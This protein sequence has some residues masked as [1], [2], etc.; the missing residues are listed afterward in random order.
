[1]PGPPPLPSP[2][3]PTPAD[4]RRHRQTGD[5]DP[6]QYDRCWAELPAEG[7]DR[8]DL[9]FF[10]CTLRSAGTHVRQM[11]GGGD[12]PIEHLAVFPTAVVVLAAPPNREV[13]VRRHPLGTLTWT[14]AKAA[15][16]RGITDYVANLS[17]SRRGE[18]A[19]A[20]AL[21]V[22]SEAGEQTLVLRS[23]S[24]VDDLRELLPS[25]VLDRARS[26]VA[27]GRNVR[28]ED[29]LARIPAGTKAHAAAERLRAE[30]GTIATVPADHRAGL[31]GVA[32]GARGRLRFDRRGLEFFDEIEGRSV[33]VPLTHVKRVLEVRKG[34]YPAEY[35]KRIEAQRKKVL[36]ARWAI[37]DPLIYLGAQAAV[38]S[39]KQELAD[40]RYG[41]PLANR[42]VLLVAIQ[43]KA[44]PV[45]FDVAGTERSAVERT[46]SEF[47][48]HLE[49]LI[50]GREPTTP[51]G[52][53]YGWEPPGIR[54]R[55]TALR[56]ANHLTGEDYGFLMTVLSA[57]SRTP[58]TAKPQAASK[59][60]EI[61]IEVKLP[62]PAKAKSSGPPPVPAA[63]PPAAEPPPV[64]KSEPTEPISAEIEP[65]SP[66]LDLD[67]GPD[68][69]LELGEDAADVDA[70]LDVPEDIG[71]LDAVFD[72]GLDAGFGD[73]EF[74]M[75]VP[76][77]E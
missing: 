44:V 5:Y 73:T 64:P 37:I 19:N 54:D 14:F 26:L 27:R 72:P 66:D 56:S 8:R 38:A 36:A 60:P 49:A 58:E 24:A 41:Q 12:V 13:I 42:L 25:V 59:I 50:P 52:G 75:D 63:K 40:A 6:D 4:P 65:E 18:L 77:T 74:G 33:R 22:K 46:A 28:A 7:F 43:G 53:G 31:P 70:A 51:A 15:D 1:M 30:V 61:K 68:L 29:Y 10:G 71:E 55:L 11:F 62:E 32:A 17:D 67:L 34:L 35:T 16:A 57:G 47:H 3:S 20:I 2:T 39:A 23:G 76:P 9:L 48:V 69:D 45:L 21:T